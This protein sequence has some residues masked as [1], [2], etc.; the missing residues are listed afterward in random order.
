VVLAGGSGS[1]FGAERNK[2][3]L[4]LA[5]RPML[6]WSLGRARELPEVGPVVLVIRPEDAAEAQVVL[7]AAGPVDRVVVIPGGSTRQASEAAALEHLAPC[8]ENGT[9]Q[10]VAIHDGARPLAGATLLRTAILTAA[11]HGGAVPALRVDDVWPLADGTVHPPVTPLYRVQTP[12]AF[13]A[14]P[15]LRAHRQAAGRDGTDTAAVLEDHPQPG[16][17]VVA[18]PGEERNVKITTAA[19]LAAAERLL[20]RR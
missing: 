5:G 1:R 16:V 14:L 11:R 18:V 8:I 13:R 15:L 12:Q 4:P 17:R 6:A 7:D 3:Y 20:S 2:V 10:V 19:D 9:V